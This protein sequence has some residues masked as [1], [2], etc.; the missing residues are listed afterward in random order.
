M[1]ASLRACMNRSYS[2]AADSNGLGSLLGGKYLGFLISS[3]AASL[4]SSPSSPSTSFP[5]MPIFFAPLLVEFG[6][7]IV[8]SFFLGSSFP[9]TL[10][11]LSGLPADASYPGLPL[12]L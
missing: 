1:S 7:T 12:P 10:S 2:Y 4:A 6:A 9:F 3:A 8:E 5:S 11:L